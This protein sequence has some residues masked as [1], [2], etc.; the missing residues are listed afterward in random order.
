MTASRRAGPPSRFA[1]LA[2]AALEKHVP[3]ARG[4][5]ATWVTKPNLAWVRVR[6]GDGT[7]G[8]FALRRHLD[9]IT[10]EAALALDPV[11]LDA[12]PLAAPEAAGGAAPGYRV[13]LG[14][15]LHDEDRWWP[16]GKGEGELV[17]RLEW[18]VLQL[19]VKAEGYFA[20]HPLTVEGRA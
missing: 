19:R 13:R 6:R 7:H 18:L 15:L 9:W 2:R 17:E 10:G 12:L 8:Y 16:A 20:R 11:A 14:A 4:A 1:R 3:D 5:G